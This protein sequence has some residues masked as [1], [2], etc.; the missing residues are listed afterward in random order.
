V[1]PTTSSHAGGI[2]SI[3]K[4]RRIGHNPK[5]PCKLCKGY[6]LTHLFPRLP[7][8][9]RLW[10]MY[11]SSSNYES[12]EVSSQPIHLLVDEVVMSLQSSAN[13]TP[14]LRGD[15]PVDHVVSQPIQPVVK[16]VVMLMQSSIDPTPF[17]GGD[18]PLDHVIL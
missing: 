16:K 9:R 7:E 5:F 12:S 18:A 17:L 14:I 15:M 4:P 6:H 13:P 8:V 1:Q 3:E 11:A 2:N 10:S